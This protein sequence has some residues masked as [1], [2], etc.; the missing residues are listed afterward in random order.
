MKAKEVKIVKEV[1][2]SDGLQRKG[3][4]AMRKG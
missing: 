1:K 2:G 3:F 4:T